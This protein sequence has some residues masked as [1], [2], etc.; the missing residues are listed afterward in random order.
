MTPAAAMWGAARC[1]PS[2]QNRGMVIP[3]G[4]SRAIAKRLPTC[5]ARIS[6]PPHRFAHKQDSFGKKSA[7]KGFS[8]LAIDV[9]T[10]IVIAQSRSPV[11]LPAGAS[12]LSF[13]SCGERLSLSAA[14]AIFSARLNDPFSESIFFCN[15]KIEYSSASGRGGQPGTYTSTGSTWLHPCTIA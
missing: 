1:A 8:F 4:A 2:T 7:A 10:S 11:R 6:L 15:C 5:A 14:Y 3:S 12:L 13:L 9:Y